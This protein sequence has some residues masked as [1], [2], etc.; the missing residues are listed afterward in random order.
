MRSA[1]R[2]GAIAGAGIVLASCGLTGPNN[3]T[4]SKSRTTTT[5][6]KSVG[7]NF[8]TVPY[9]HADPDKYRLPVDSPL[10]PYSFDG[11]PGW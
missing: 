3:S 2:L 4:S 6:K 7:T 8:P 10:I 1:A 9:D 11:T 5:A